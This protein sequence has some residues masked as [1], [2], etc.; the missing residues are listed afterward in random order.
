MEKIIKEL[1]KKFT[2][3]EIKESLSD[4]CFSLFVDN[5]FLGLT[6][7]YDSLNDQT[8][9][10]EIIETLTRYKSQYAETKTD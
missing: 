10:D 1:L 6:V 5:I 9:I 3:I 8:A 2:V 7:S 4:G